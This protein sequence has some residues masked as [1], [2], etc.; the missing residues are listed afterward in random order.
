MELGQLGN[1]VDC[2]IFEGSREHEK[3]IVFLAD[4]STN[5]RVHPPPLKNA[6]LSL[7]IKNKCLECSETKDY[8]KIFCEIFAWVSI[9]NLDIFH[10]NFL[11]YWNFLIFFP[12]EPKYFFSSESSI[13]DFVSKTYIFIHVKKK[14]CI[15]SVCPLK[16]RGGGGQGL[17]GRLR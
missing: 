3:N 5:E 8:A 9:K 17:S 2:K 12:L 4:G 15:K 13:S 11:R 10:N 6:S 7:K 1:R 16:A 14:A